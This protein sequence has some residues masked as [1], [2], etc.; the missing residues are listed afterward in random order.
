MITFH[1]PTDRKLLAA[2]GEVALRHEH[3]NHILRMTVKSLADLR[4]DQAL[5]ATAH[6]GSRQLRERIGKIARKR[7][8]E[9]TPLLKLQALL[10]RCRRATDRRNEL[11]HW[12]WAKKLDG[13]PIRLGP[14][15]NSCPLPTLND[16]KRLS[17][18]IESLTTELN[19]ARRKGFLFE[20]LMLRDAKRMNTRTSSKR[21][22]TPQGEGSAPRQP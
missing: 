1:V 11:M 5:D 4:P 13:E 9:G 8:G 12:I 17:S 2:F 21:M 22:A 3:L 7:L 16:L 14:D 10:E 19:I 18:D 20:A 15:H 6:D